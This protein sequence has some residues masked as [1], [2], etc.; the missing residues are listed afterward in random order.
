MKINH[1]N[2][3]SIILFLILGFSCEAFSQSENIKYFNWKGKVI[4]NLDSAIIPYATIKVFSNSRIFIFNAN[5]DGLAEVSYCNPTQLDTIFISSI[6]YK[7]VFISC[8]KLTNK[9]IIYLCEDIISLNEVVIKSQKKIKTI[10]LGNKASFALGSGGAN[11]GG[12]GALFI[13]DENIKGKIIKIRYYMGGVVLS[14]LGGYDELLYHPFR[15]RLYDKDTIHQT[16]GKDILNK[17]LII[18]LNKGKWIEIDIAEYNVCI[19]K[20]GIFVGFEVLPKEYYFNEKIISSE[21][22]GKQNFINSISIG[23]TK[24]SK[25]CKLEDWICISPYN[26]WMKMSGRPKDNWISLINVE[27]KPE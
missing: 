27:V 13:P 6:G 22:I 12:Q 16:V 11:F 17:N 23:K 1:S 10:T 24:V 3:I 8:I 4:S 18:S 5:K 9:N 19:P 20:G 2:S 7:P 14:M 15:V 21:K 25:N 26:K